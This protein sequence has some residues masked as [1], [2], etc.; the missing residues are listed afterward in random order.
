MKRA[1]DGESRA[2][3][4]MLL[5]TVQQEGESCAGTAPHM[6]LPQRTSPL[7]GALPTAI[8][9]TVTALSVAVPSVPQPR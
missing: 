1:V 9:R 3:L 7:L 5:S 6:T 8:A 4:F 2:G